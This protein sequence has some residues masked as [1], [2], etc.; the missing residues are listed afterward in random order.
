MLLIQWWRWSKL[1]PAVEA[2]VVGRP[3]RGGDKR[4]S[5]SLPSGQGEP[6]AA[7]D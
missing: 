5:G 6:V 3:V 4:I 7:H 1:G 2:T